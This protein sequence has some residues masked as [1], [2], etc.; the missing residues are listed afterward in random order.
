M[1]DSTPELQAA[2]VQAG[3]SPAYIARLFAIESGGDPN[4][5]TGSNRGLGQFGPQEEARYGLSDANRADPGAQATAVAREAQEHT[6]VLR[7]V[8]GRDPTPGEMYLTHQQGVAGGP[9]L[10]SAQPDMPAWQ[11]IRPYY[12]SEA[13]A[14]KAITGNVPSDHPLYGQ[15]ADRI[16]AADFRNLW[17]NKFER[18]LG[19]APAAVGSQAAQPTPAAMGGA[20]APAPGIL[21]AQPSLD[22]DPNFLAV[23]QRAAEMLAPQAAPPPLPSINFPL[24]RGLNRARLLAALSQPVGG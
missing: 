18:G 5:V 16:T 17:V 10:L 12:K 3:A 19:G 4:A 1:P 9:A 11:V 24:P 21:N 14:R 20:A 6:A 15:D 13:I 7:K 8:L 22:S 23:S 2:L